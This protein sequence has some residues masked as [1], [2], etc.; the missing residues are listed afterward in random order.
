[1]SSQAWIIKSHIIP[2][3]HI[4]GYSRGVQ[5]ECSEIPLRLAVKQYTP[6]SNTSPQAG[7]VTI[8]FTPGLA[9]SK[10]SFEPFY[11]D[12]LLASNEQFRIRAI[13]AADPAF[14]AAS[15]VLNEDVIGEHPNWID[16][17]RDLIHM[18]NYFQKHMPPPIFG[19]GES[20]GVGPIFMMSSWHPRLFAGIVAIEPA[21][22]PGLEGHKWPTLPKLHPMALVSRRKDKWPSRE[23]ATKHLSKNPHYAAMDKRV[24]AIAL[25]YDLR[26]VYL[27][28]PRKLGAQGAL[29]ADYI[30][31]TTPKAMEAYS[32]SRPDPPLFGPPDRYD[33]AISHANAIIVPGFYRP[34]AS[35]IYES[36][37]HIYPPV[38]CIWGKKS[39]IP[40]A[41]MRDVM[42]MIGV[43]S[44]GG[45]GLS[46]G[47]VTQ[48]F[49]EGAGHAASLHKPEG[50]AQATVPWFAAEI[51]RWREDWEKRK[52]R[53]NFSKEL[54]L[55]WLQRIAKL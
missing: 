47:Q 13:W 54:P 15:Y 43:G 8:I 23:E 38:L 51:R 46:N 37:P 31:L 5:D 26:D 27:K 18:V 40:K 25:K 53:L 3:S 17:A 45:G 10:E 14:S 35:Q 21:L 12:L 41:Y 7:D 1:M 34:E 30:T 20:W 22:G 9:A 55:E 24:L 42:S 19:M 2:A 36:L 48:R 44:N 28:E 16:H 32:W 39:Y 49:V 4:R 50:V 11:D 52:I 29:P 33:A 6:R